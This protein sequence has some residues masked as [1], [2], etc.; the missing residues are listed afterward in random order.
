MKQLHY[1]LALLLLTLLL[2]TACTPPP[3]QAPPLQAEQT[4][5]RGN[6]ALLEGD[7]LS[8]EN[9][10]RAALTFQPLPAEAS[11][12]RNSVVYNN[13]GNAFYRQARWQDTQDAYEQAL[14]S[15]N[16]PQQAIH[17]YNLGNVFMQRLQLEAQLEKQLNQPLTTSPDTPSTT[18]P[19]D[20]SPEQLTA[21]ALAHYQDAL[22]RN[23][24]DEDAKYN[25]E[26]VLQQNEQQNEQQ[27]QQQNQP[28]EQQ[29]QD[30][31]QD[32]QDQQGDNDNQDDQDNQDEQDEQQDDQ[33]QDDQDNE[34]QPEEDDQD[35]QQDNQ[36][37]GQP[38]PPDPGDQQQATA[39]P[40]LTQAQAIQLLEA[41]AQQSDTLQE[42]LQRMMTPLP[43]PEQDW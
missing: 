21:A 35:N 13:L 3:L 29:E 25:L 9:H 16:R 27:N 34:G 12:A 37:E 18:T 33:D 17:H 24:N 8:A 23:P 7:L 20:V 32:D 42:Y 43:P 26:L 15:A 2:L 1:A 39:P 4:I 22:R 36:D 40:P 5:E 28:E 10:Y 41:A 19:D 38:E 31:Q 11:L 14:T 30:E 6:A